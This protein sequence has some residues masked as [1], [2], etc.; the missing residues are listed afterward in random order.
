MIFYFIATRPY[1]EKARNGVMYLTIGEARRVCEKAN[2]FQIRV[3]YRVF[4]AEAV[5]IRDVE[6]LDA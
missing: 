5:N 3:V 1:I 2:D 4:Q 6:E